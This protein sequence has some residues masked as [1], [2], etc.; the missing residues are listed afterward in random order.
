MAPAEDGRMTIAML[1]ESGQMTLQILTFVLKLAII[2]GHAACRI[3]VAYLADSGIIKSPN[4]KCDSSLPLSN[5]HT[6]RTSLKRSHHE[7]PSKLEDQGR[8]V[9]IK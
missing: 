3:R 8:V 4:P 2:V 5:A 7:R 1:C 6:P 9:I